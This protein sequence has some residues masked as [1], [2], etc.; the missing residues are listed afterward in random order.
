MYM[1][2]TFFKRIAHAF[3]ISSVFS[4]TFESIHT[5]FFNAGTNFAYRHPTQTTLL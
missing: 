2:T 3:Q 5:N 4:L 1:T